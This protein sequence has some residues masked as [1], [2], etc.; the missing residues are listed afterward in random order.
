MR[1]IYSRS[2][3][4]FG[5]LVRAASW[6]G[7]W[8]HCGIVTGDG[9]VIHAHALRG[10]VEEPLPEFAKRYSLHALVDVSAPNDDIGIAWARERIGDGYDYGGIVRYISRKLSD[11]SP[12]RWSCAELVETALIAAGCVR[13]RCE[14]HEVTPHQSYISRAAL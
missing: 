5:W 6:W 12:R 4:P 8:S 14:P 7:Q 13:W 9:T 2:R 3:T 10:V 11:H 1:L